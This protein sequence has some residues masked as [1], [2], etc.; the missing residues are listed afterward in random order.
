VAI[1]SWSGETGRQKFD[2][3]ILDRPHGLTRDDIPE[4]DSFARCDRKEL[5]ILRDFDRVDKPTAFRSVNTPP[6]ARFENLWS[7]PDFRLPKRAGA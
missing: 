4:H 6:G 7:N 2:L 3:D 5:T 1:I